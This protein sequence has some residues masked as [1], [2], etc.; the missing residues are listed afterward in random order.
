MS[1]S[2]PLP[3]PDLG[4]HLLPVLCALPAPQSEDVA[5]GL[6]R[7][8]ESGVDKPVR[9]LTVTDLHVDRADEHRRMLVRR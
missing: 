2:S 8:M 6:G 7:D 4:E 3:V 9:E 5:V 1:T